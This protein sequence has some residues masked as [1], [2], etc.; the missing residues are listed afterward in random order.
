MRATVM[1]GA[2][3]VRIESVP[4]AR[5][6]EPTDALVVVTRA[7]ICGS[8]L[9]PYKKMERSETGRRMDTSSS[10]LS[11]PLAQMSVPSRS[12]M[13]L[14]H[15]SRGPTEPASS[16]RRGCTPL[17]CT[18]VF[19]AVLTSMADRGRQCASRRQTARLSS[20]RSAQT[21]R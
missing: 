20:C 12:A 9:W 11:R 2:G 16:A 4:D 3:D 10:A 6:I 13:S 8:D 1:Y 7:A 19:G 18:E 15:R 17:A 21:T 5:I 14:R